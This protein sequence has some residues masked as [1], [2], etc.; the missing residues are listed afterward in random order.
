MG[1]RLPEHAGIVN[2]GRSVLAVNPDGPGGRVLREEFMSKGK[3][4]R[5]AANDDEIGFAVRCRRRSIGGEAR[6]FGSRPGIGRQHPGVAE[7]AAIQVLYLALVVLVDPGRRIER[8][9]G[10]AVDLLEADEGERALVVGD[11][12]VLL[13]HEEH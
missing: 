5:H 3:I 2:Q 1:A 4:A 13:V 10:G 8:P 7:A 12:R 11:P 9:A 6:G